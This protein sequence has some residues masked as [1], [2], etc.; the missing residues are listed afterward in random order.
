MQQSQRKILSLAFGV[1]LATFAAGAFAADAPASEEK[2]LYESVYSKSYAQ[3]FGGVG[4]V[5]EAY[6]GTK[7][8]QDWEPSLVSKPDGTKVWSDLRTIYI[9]TALDPSN[10]YSS[11]N[12][13]VNVKFS[14]LNLVNEHV[15]RSNTFVLSDG[16]S[17]KSASRETHL[18]FEGSVIK[19]WNIVVEEPTYREYFGI[20]DGERSTEHSITFRNSEFTGDIVHNSKDAGLMTDFSPLVSD[21][22]NQLNLDLDG[23]KWTGATYST[24]TSKVEGGNSTKQE[25]DETSNHRTSLLLANNSHW[26]VTDDSFVTTL[27]ADSDSDVEILAGTAE[28]KTKLSIDELD[29]GVRVNVNDNTSLTVGKTTDPAAAVLTDGETTIHELDVRF[30][31][32][33]NAAVAVRADNVS[34]KLVASDTLRAEY[35]DDT[36]IRA[37]AKA[38]HT[39]EETVRFELEQGLFSDGVSGTVSHEGDDTFQVNKT[40]R[41]T[42]ENALAVADT[43][44]ILFMQWRAE[45]DDVMQRMGDVR[46]SG[47]TGL[48]VRHYGGRSEFGSSDYDYLALQMGADRLVYDGDV[49]VLAGAAFS[50]TDGDAKYS[51]GTSDAKSYA[52]TAYGELLTQSGSFLTA[53]LKYGAL[54][55][56]VELSKTI[57]GEFRADAWAFS[58]ETGHRFALAKSFFVEPHVGLTYAKVNGDSFRVGDNASVKQDDFDSLVGG[59]GLTLGFSCPNDRGDVYL[60]LDQKYDFQGETSTGFYSNG[61]EV[62]RFDKDLGGSWFE[63]GLGAKARLTESLTGYAEFETAH[64]GEVETPFRWNLGLRY[65]F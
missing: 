30:K 21:K 36:I 1:A 16:N 15:S 55:N 28:K 65:T 27:K 35:D 20:E 29:S 13:F 34:T 41:T 26:A 50:Y 38:V 4:T 2:P 44:S 39:K 51:T 19:H 61:R 11:I 48:W 7:D 64:S 18:A 14:G 63:I 42:N 53:A 5:G 56:E 54:R 40:N 12:G 9:N 59:V 58:V 37:M 43:G 3:Y 17:D 33:E 31:G 10:R 22:G 47:K 6:D 32:L 24:I 8:I 23:T 52:F 25:R 60:R 57:D 62:N 46:S 49:K 45:T